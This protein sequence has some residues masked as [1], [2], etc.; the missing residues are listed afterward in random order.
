MYA[1]EVYRLTDGP[2]RA[3]CYL[4]GRRVSRVYYDAQH[5]GRRTDSYATRIT[6]RPDGPEL[7]RH[8]HCIRVRP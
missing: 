5:M 3:R 6:T 1:M 4:N 7:V 2:N 8:Y